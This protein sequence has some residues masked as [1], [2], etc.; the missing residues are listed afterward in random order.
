DT[1]PSPSF[2]PFCEE[3]LA[4]YREDPR[5]WCICGMN[6]YTG[7]MARAD[8]TYIFTRYGLTNGWA[9]WRRAWRHYDVD[10]KSWPTLKGSGRMR[11]LFPNLVERWFWTQIFDRQYEGKIGSWDYQWLYTRLVHGGLTAAPIVNMV[12]NL[13]FR[14]DATHATKMSKRLE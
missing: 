4:R 5:V 13:G 11:D 10:M 6:L 3:L 2:Y 7:P 1:L 8:E 12:A 14:A 9:S